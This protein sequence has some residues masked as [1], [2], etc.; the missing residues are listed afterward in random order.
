VDLDYEDE[1]SPDEEGTEAVAPPEAGELP[2]EVRKHME[3]QSRRIEKLQRELADS[4]LTVYPEN[5]RAIVQ[6][7][8]LPP[9]KWGEFAETVKAQFPA[10]TAPTDQAT[11]AEAEQAP[12]P[13]EQALA[14]VNQGPNAVGALTKF[15]TPEEIRQIGL[16]DQAA[17]LR[18]LSAQVDPATGELRRG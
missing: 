6:A 18:I 9:T 2:Q 8:G 12:N 4:R 13:E 17:A 7:S 15:Y 16:K 1:E 11:E 10:Q 14:A 5:V 3:R